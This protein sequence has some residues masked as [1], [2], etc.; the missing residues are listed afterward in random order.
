MVFIHLLAQQHRHYSLLQVIHHHTQPSILLITNQP[1]QPIIAQK[2][3][4]NLYRQIIKIFTGC[5]INFMPFI[6]LKKD[7]PLGCLVTLNWLD[8]YFGH[9]SN[10]NNHHLIHHNILTLTTYLIFFIFNLAQLSQNYSSYLQNLLVFPLTFRP[11][12]PPLF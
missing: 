5:F 9:H 8:R 12:S 4:F 2:M 11:S 6:K 10:H 3:I 1:C 7:S